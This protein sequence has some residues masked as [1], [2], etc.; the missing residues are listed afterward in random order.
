[1]AEGGE[2]EVSRINGETLEKARRELGEEPGRREGS[3]RELRTKIEEEEENEGVCY[4]RKDNKFLLMFLRAR[5]FNVDRSLQLYVNYHKYRQKYSH[6]L[7]DYH[8]TAVEDVLKSG[9]VRVVDERSKNGP[10]VIILSPAHWDTQTVPFERNFKT[11]LLI[12]DKLIEDEHNQ[13]HGFVFINNLERVSLYTIVSLART[14]HVKKGIF[15]ELM[16]EAFPA[17]FKGLHLVNQ[18]WYISIV[19]TIV[20]PFMKQ[21]LKDRVHLHGG[22]YASLHE[23]LNPEGL[24]ASFGGLLPD[25]DAANTLGLFQDELSVTQ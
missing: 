22:D 14:E 18:P 11:L 2:E 13:I 9:M 3:I 5:K 20:R 25:L 17:R 4:E 16:Q 8:P 12:L 21:K 10:K 1:M 19:M 7:T 6:L 23:H 15:M 24:P